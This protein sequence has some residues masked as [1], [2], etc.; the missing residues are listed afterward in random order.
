M[1]EMF[2]S[3]CACSDIDDMSEMSESAST[4]LALMV[5]VPSR[6]CR[7]EFDLR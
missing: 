7:G 6:K 1:S 5:L 4:L 2:I 3:A